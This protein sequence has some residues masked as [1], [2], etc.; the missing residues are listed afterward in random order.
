ML[1]TESRT[2]VKHRH[3]VG[4]TG[5]HSKVALCHFAQHIALVADDDLNGVYKL[6]HLLGQSTQLVLGLVVDL[7]AEVAFCHTDGNIFEFP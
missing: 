7:G 6:A 1:V 5:I 4:N 3:N 2:A